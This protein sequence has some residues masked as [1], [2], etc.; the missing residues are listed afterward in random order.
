SS[1]RAM[2][3]LADQQVEARLS[4]QPAVVGDKVL[5]G[6]AADG[7]W[8]VL[9]V[10][11]RRTKLS[12]PDVDNPNRERV[13]AANVDIIVIVV[14][15]VSPPLHPRLID[16]YLVAIEQ[17]GAKP[18]ICV[19]KMDLLADSSELEALEPYKKL[20]IPV[21]LCSTANPRGLEELRECLKE[22]VCAF[23]GHSGV[24]KSSL[25]NALK[26]DANVDT[27]DV[28]EGYGRGTHTTTASS[29]HHLEDGTTLIDTPGIR[30]F[31]MWDLAQN[32]IS[33]YFPE[34]ANC[35]CRY[36]NCT[37]THEPHCAVLEAVENGGVDPRRYDAYI[38]LCQ[39]K[40]D[41]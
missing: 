19:N 17:G 14:S 40:G 12:R 23:V 35:R 10:A 11:P 29:L 38:R 26:P 33:Q 2:V 20:G 15:V 6:Q 7:E 34:F 3:E 27:G 25:L 31:G 1:K 30:S 36:N 8:G 13:V 22:K 9:S 21:V 39:E 32:E 16:R 5:L 41:K 4:G 37:H 24:G 18:V 28:S